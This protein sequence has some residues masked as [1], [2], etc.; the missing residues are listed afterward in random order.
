MVVPAWQA[1]PSAKFESVSFAL[2]QHTATRHRGAS[3]TVDRHCA[4]KSAAMRPY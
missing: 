1:L 4:I 3:R 2:N